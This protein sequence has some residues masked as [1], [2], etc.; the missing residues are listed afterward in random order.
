MNHLILQ[1]F[2]GTKTLINGERQHSDNKG[3]IFN[4]FYVKFLALIKEWLGLL[5]LQAIMI[6]KS[7]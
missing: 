7:L 6:K 5:N 3:S 2:L 4:A 1:R